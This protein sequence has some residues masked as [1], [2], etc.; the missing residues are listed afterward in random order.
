MAAFEQLILSISFRFTTAV[1]LSSAYSGNNSQRRSIVAYDDGLLV[2]RFCEA[3]V[4]RTVAYSITIFDT[5]DINQQWWEHAARICA[6][7]VECVAGSGRIWRAV[8]Q[9]NAER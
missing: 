2:C 5:A 8:W 6:A 7:N 9:R 4:L 1:L 3:V